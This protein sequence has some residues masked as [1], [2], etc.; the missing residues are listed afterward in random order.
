MT[1]PYLGKAWEAYSRLFSENDT[2]AGIVVYAPYDLQPDE[3]AQVMREF[4]NDAFPALN[5]TLK[6]GAPQ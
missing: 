2:S 6:A 1:N 4:L 5:Q 3:A